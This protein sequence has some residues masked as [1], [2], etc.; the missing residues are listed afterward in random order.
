MSILSFKIIGWLGVL[1]ASAANPVRADRVEAPTPEGFAAIAALG[2]HPDYANAVELRMGTTLK[3]EIKDTDAVVAMFGEPVHYK[4]FKIPA[5]ARERIEI[6]SPCSCFGLVKKIMPP[7][8]VL[9][10]ADGVQV[11]SPVY[12][13]VVYSPTVPMRYMGVVSISDMT[14][15]AQY[16]VVAPDPRVLRGP[17]KLKIEDKKLHFPIPVHYK[18]LGKL[19]VTYGYPPRAR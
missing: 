15:T 14:D 4:V 2:G 8:A 19:R 11:G 6:E 16:L 18:P 1:A 9:L 12:F 10:T 5:G 3:E 17:K 7:T 13:D